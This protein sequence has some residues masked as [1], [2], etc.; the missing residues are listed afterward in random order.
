MCVLPSVKRRRKSS[1]DVGGWFVGMGGWMGGRAGGR[2]KGG[3]GEREGEGR[4][5]EMYGLV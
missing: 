2:E 3:E 5:R 4:G 1:G